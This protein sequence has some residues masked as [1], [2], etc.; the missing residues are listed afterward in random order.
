MIAVVAPRALVLERGPAAVVPRFVQRIDRENGSMST[1]PSFR[2]NR[3][4][5]LHGGCVELD[6]DI[7][8]QLKGVTPLKGHLEV[9]QTVQEV[10]PVE[11]TG[12]NRAA[13]PP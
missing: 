9:L 12:E 6:M 5:K 2:H 1:P 7:Q 4:T 13:S 10:H 11:E 8:S 3:K